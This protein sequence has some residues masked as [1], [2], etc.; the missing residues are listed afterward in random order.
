[1]VGLV[2]CG[3]RDWMKL[4]NSASSVV[5]AR[6]ERQKALLSEKGNFNYVTL[7]SFLAYIAT[8]RLWV[9]TGVSGEFIWPIN[10]PDDINMYAIRALR[11]KWKILIEFTLLVGWLGVERGG[12]M[13]FVGEGS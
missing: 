10:S 9:E 2:W 1:M 4:E 8:M 6:A 12:R 13:R 11:E 7:P 5:G 3:V